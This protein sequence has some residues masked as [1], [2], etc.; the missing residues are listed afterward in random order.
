[1]NYNGLTKD[2]H[3]L[4]KQNRFEKALL[5]F[6]LKTWT[7]HNEKEKMAH[8][9]I[10][11]EGALL[12]AGIA[13]KNWFTPSLANYSHQIL[14]LLLLPLCAL[15]HMMVRWQLRARREAAICTAAIQSLMFRFVT[16]PPTF[17]EMISKEP[18]KND[19]NT[20]DATLINT[21]IDFIIPFPSGTNS[22]SET[23]IPICLQDAIRKHQQT[24]A[25]EPE[26][27]A[28]IASLILLSALIWVLAFLPTVSRAT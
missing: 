12:A 3:E 13:S 2:L 14:F 23:R 10:V 27:M 6:Y 16:E 21:L 9:F 18:F 7:Y 19:T 22:S 4:E 28:T 15:L 20:R 8:N 24:K 11:L 26:W 17:E 25:F 5:A 1:M